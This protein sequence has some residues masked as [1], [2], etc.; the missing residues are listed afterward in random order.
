MPDMALA[1]ARHNVKVFKGDQQPEQLAGCNCIV[2]ANCPV[3]IEARTAS[4]KTGNIQG[5]HLQ[6]FQGEI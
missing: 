3:V 1:V 5:I 4:G 2:P 6:N